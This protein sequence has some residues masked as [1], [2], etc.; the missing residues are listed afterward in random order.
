MNNKI[1]SYIS[2]TLVTF[3]WGLSFISTKICLKW[4]TPISL[5]FYR[6]LIATI[7]LFIIL[8]LTEKNLKI[9]KTDIFKIVLMG[10]TGM[11]LYFTFENLALSLMSASLASVL[12]ALMPAFAVLGDFFILK[13]PISKVKIISVLISIVG[14]CL[15]AGFNS[16][17]N[18]KNL[19]LGIILI[20]V[21]LVSWLAYNYLSIPLQKKYSTIK[22]TFYQTV[23]GTLFFLICLPFSRTNFANF[24]SVGLLNLLFLGVLCS[25]VC[26]LLYNYSLNHIDVV[27][28]SIFINLMPIITVTA[29]VIILHEKV[30]LIQILGTSLVI[31]SVF[32]ATKEKS[33]NISNY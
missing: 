8:I 6:F 32:V 30:S 29:S 21:S 13:K 12:I 25:A 33:S 11:F 9:D 14:A 3:F 24:S 7:V 15:V 22:I 1:K 19:V 31:L 10:F 28:C 17:E 27:I 4:F 26:Y 2:I 23:F 18:S 20:M 16:E 5:A